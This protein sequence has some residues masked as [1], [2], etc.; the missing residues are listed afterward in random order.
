MRPASRQ[1][2]VRAAQD[3]VCQRADIQGKGNDQ[4]LPLVITAAG[5]TE[6]SI[7]AGATPPGGVAHA[8]IY[9]NSAG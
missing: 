7:K 5:S 9:V 2:Q 6:I 3:A 1:I 4:S 8:I